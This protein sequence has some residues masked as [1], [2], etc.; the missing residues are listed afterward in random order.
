MV[1]PSV[2]S[3]AMSM[4]SIDVPLISPIARQ[5]REPPPRVSIPCRT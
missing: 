5:V 1:S 3:A 2:S 4:P